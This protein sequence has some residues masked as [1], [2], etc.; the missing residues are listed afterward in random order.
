MSNTTLLKFEGLFDVGQKIRAYD[1]NPDDV[2][3][4][5]IYAEGEIVSIEEFPI[6]SYRILCEV[7]TGPNRESKYIYIPMEISSSEFDSRIVSI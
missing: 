7:C 4:R 5:E 1:Y 2:S 3:G 6:K